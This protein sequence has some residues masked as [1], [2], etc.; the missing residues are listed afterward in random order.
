M[1]TKR[2]CIGLILALA[3]L[4]SLVDLWAKSRTTLVVDALSDRLECVSYAPFRQD[5]QTPLDRTAVIAPDAIDQDMA[6]LAKRFNCVRIYS[7]SQGLQ[8]VPELAARHGLQVLL[9]I[10]IG[11]NRSDNELE[12]NRATRNENQ[13]GVSPPPRRTVPRSRP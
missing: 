8:A 7:V 13:V 3:A 12:L 1:F 5:G 10:W 11:A 4:L 2:A 6:L 9:G